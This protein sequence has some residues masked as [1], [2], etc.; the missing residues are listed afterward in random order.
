MSE[1]VSDGGV[2]WR[3]R[4]EGVSWRG[5]GVNRG[6][7]LRVADTISGRVSFIRLFIGF[8]LEDIRH[9]GYIL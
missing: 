3:E 8:L 1:S 7:F 4:E 6:G 9:Y 2:E 5:G